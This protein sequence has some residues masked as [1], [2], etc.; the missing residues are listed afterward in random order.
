MTSTPPV[1]P[2]RLLDDRVAGCAGAHQRLNTFLR[3][4]AD[5][6]GLDPSAPSALPD[7]TVGHVLTHIARN[8]DA[9][10]Y[11]IEG[12]IA[13]EVR[14]MYPGGMEQRNGDIE[15]GSTRTVEELVA[16]VRSAGWALEGSW[17]RLSAEAWQRVGLARGTELP[18]KEF[19]WRRWREVEV[20]HSDLGLDGFTPE[21][22]SAE[23]VAGE[24]PAQVAAWAS[25]NSEPIPAVV[26]A[27]PP[28]RQLAWFMGRNTG[29]GLPPAPTWV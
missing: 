23:F 14:P 1:D 28:W 15:T 27:A 19:P 29:P 24:L 10:R 7:W 12:A 21:H 25:A 5:S 6:C 26:T 2:T 8:A 4:A 17:A 22:W 9:L 20:H 13:N 16:D 3:E 18:V 11:M